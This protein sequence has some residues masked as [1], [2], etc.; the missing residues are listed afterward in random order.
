MT[1]D[2]SI[3]V[4][5]PKNSSRQLAEAVLDNL[6]VSSTK[7]GLAQFHT[8]ATESPTFDVPRGTDYHGYLP[9]QGLP[10]WVRVTAI[11]PGYLPRVVSDYQEQLEPAKIRQ[12]THLVRILH[13]YEKAAENRVDAAILAL[14]RTY[15]VIWIRDGKFAHSAW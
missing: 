3:F 15:K 1:A 11:S 14:A 5:A 13:S 4:I 2:H 10:G 9:E 12:A 6:G 8:A 7:I